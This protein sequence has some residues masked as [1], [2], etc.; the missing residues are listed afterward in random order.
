MLIN[1]NV[2]LTNLTVTEPPAVVINGINLTQLTCHNFCD[3]IA[4]VQATNATS[5]T[6]NSN[7]SQATPIFTDLCTG[8]YT[9]IAADVNGCSTSQSFQFNQSRTRYC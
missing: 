4:D 6:L 2:V 5:Y 9:I 7:P 1:C 8:S 3:G